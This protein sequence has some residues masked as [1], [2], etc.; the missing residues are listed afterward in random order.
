MSAHAETGSAVRRLNWGCGSWTEPGWINCDSKEGPGIDVSC[1]IRD[2][3]PFE[4]G[5]MDYVVSIHALPEVPYPDLMPVLVEL[6]RVLKAG[7][8]LRLGLPDLDRGID[9]YLRR[10]ATHFMVPDEEMTSLSGKF[11][12]HILWFGYTR[13]LFTHP[14]IEEL[15][16]RAGFASVTPCGFRD[17]LSAHPGIVE[18]DNRENESLFVEALKGG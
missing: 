3:L 4:D 14:F 17:T 5:S 18:L 11:I 6:G 15:L 1:D 9:A 10:D 16:V 13:T 2:G 12:M 7:G 8:V